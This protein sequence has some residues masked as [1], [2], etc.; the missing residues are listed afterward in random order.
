MAKAN[1]YRCYNCEDP[2]RSMPGFNFSNDTGVCPKCTLSIH[3]PIYGKIVTKLRILHFDPPH[4]VVKFRGTG[5]FPCKTP[6]Q[7]GQ[8]FTGV[9]DEVNCP[10]CRASAAWKKAKELADSS[11][12]DI[13]ENADFKITVDLVNQQL[14][15][16][17]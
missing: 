1:L 12:D 7:S 14:V 13:V 11:P 2:E 6:R 5:Q 15:E 17:T 4:P 8:M 16:V 9:A 3:D 10:G